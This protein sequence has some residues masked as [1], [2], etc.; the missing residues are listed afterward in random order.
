MPGRAHPH[1]LQVAESVHEPCHE[2]ELIRCA[3]T[4]GAGDVHLGEP[5]PKGRMAPQLASQVVDKRAESH[6]ERTI[7]TTIR[8][9]TE[10]PQDRVSELAWL[11]SNARQQDPRELG[12][13]LTLKEPD[14]DVIAGEHSRMLSLRRLRR[15]LDR[16]GQRY[17]VAALVKNSSTGVSADP[18]NQRL[19]QTP[20]R[21]FEEHRS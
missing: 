2:L 7:A 8:A 18:R 9:A 4:S 10:R 16:F 12:G 3:R 20:G 1:C 14:I 17:A 5:R 6:H 21:R 19:R 15:G 11:G 13:A